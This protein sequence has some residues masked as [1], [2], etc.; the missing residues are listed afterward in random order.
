[1]F[2]C[3]CSSD[4][5]VFKCV[6][7]ASVSKGDNKAVSHECELSPAERFGFESAGWVQGQ[8]DFSSCMLQMFSVSRCLHSSNACATDFHVK[9]MSMFN[10]CFSLGEIAFRPTSSHP[11]ECILSFFDLFSA[12]SLLL[13][14]RPTPSWL[15]PGRSTRAIACAIRFH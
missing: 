11:G 10:T 8:R 14:F 7:A 4:V 9:E 12:W 2:T 5:T 15:P 13:F 1:M 6:S 3:H